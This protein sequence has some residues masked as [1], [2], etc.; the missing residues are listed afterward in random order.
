MAE[1]LWKNEGEMNE[2]YGQYMRL[3]H[4]MGSC[5]SFLI[6]EWCWCGLDLYM[7]TLANKLGVDLEAAALTWYLSVP[8]T[9]YFNSV[10]HIYKPS[11]FSS[12]RKNI[13]N[14][15]QIKCRSL[16]FCISATI[17]LSYLFITR[18]SSSFS[19]KR[20]RQVGSLKLTARLRGTETKGLNACVYT[21]GKAAYK[22]LTLSLG[23]SRKWTGISGSWYSGNTSSRVL[24]SPSKKYL[25]RTREP[26]PTAR[27]LI[28]IHSLFRFR[29]LDEMPSFVHFIQSL[30][31]PP[32]RAT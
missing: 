4:H 16:H 29:R 5:R 8:F 24:Y 26:L 12:K 28:L 2:L 20:K 18:S 6:T 25:I 32:G 19:F 1:H 9:I 13:K 14:H 3:R 7:E 17:I 27:L 21:Q 22:L 10:I 31:A 30:F 15:A 23:I 11:C